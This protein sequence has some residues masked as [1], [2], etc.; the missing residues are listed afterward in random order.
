MIGR[1]GVCEEFKAEWKNYR[2]WQLVKLEKVFDVHFRGSDPLT[3]L[4]WETLK[5]EI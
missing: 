5:P 1:L 3:E 4:N 2:F